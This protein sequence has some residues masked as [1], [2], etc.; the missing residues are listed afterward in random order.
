MVGTEL[1]GLFTLRVAIGQ[2]HT[3]LEHVRRV[4][5]L[6]QQQAGLMLMNQETA[7]VESNLQS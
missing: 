6:L 1:D 5:A 4:W 2:S 3:Q 7:G